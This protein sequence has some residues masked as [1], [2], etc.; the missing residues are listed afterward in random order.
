MSLNFSNPVDS[1]IKARIKEAL[2]EPVAAD[3]RTFLFDKMKSVEQRLMK[4]VANAAAQPAVLEMND[5]GD[6]KT[7]DDGTQYKLTADGW[8]LLP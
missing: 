1:L 3:D 4:E 8:R 2:G 6:I 7:L 5:I